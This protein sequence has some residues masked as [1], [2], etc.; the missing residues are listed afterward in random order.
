MALL[1]QFRGPATS[2]EDQI[3]SFSTERAPGHARW[4]IPAISLVLLG[5]ATAILPVLVLGSRARRQRPRGRDRQRGAI[6]PR[7]CRGP[8]RRFGAARDLGHAP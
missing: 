7:R 1:D 4:P 8:Q 3:E 5:N 2:L 6:H